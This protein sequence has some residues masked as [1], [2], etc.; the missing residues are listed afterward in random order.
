MSEQQALR[1]DKPS[2]SAS[3]VTL[4]EDIANGARSVQTGSF[5]AQQSTIVWSGSEEVWQK[6]QIHCV[7]NYSALCP[8]LWRLSSYDGACAAPPSYLRSGKCRGEVDFR[9]F[10]MFDKA[11]WAMD[12]EARWPCNGD[13]PELDSSALERSRLVA[14][15]EICAAEDESP[16]V[17]Q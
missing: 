11:V 10:T 15:A 1:I 16:L 4:F 9:T 17:S 14:T 13:E 12:C 7:T 6:L 8:Q 3:S 2:W 5:D